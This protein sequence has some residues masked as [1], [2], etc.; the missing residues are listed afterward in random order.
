[1]KAF[2]ML[3]SDVNDGKLTRHATIDEARREGKIR[4][5]RDRGN[6]SDVFILKAVERVLQPVP[7][8]EVQ[9]LED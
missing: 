1:M 2:Y 7:D 9:T 8:A 5:N 6:T 4:V 3:Y